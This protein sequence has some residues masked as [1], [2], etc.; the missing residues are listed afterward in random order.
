M[1]DEFRAHLWSA[2][3]QLRTDALQKFVDEQLLESLP[4]LQEAI[5]SSEF[6]EQPRYKIAEAVGQLTESSEAQQF[7][8]ELSGQEDPFV[9]CCAAVGMK[10][11]SQAK[12]IIRLL[13]MLEDPTNKVRN[14]AERSLLNQTEAL[15]EHGQQKLLS[16][17]DHPT[18]LIRSPAARLAG[19]AKMKA[20]L[21]KLLELAQQNP[22]WLTRIWATKALGDMGEKS[23][24]ETL[25]LIL[26]QDEKNRVRAAAVESIGVLK[27]HN[28]EALLKEALNDDDAGVQ[29]RASEMLAE[30]GFEGLGADEYEFD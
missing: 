6:G 9:R 29:K 2:D 10:S 20:A 19:S 12:A 15:C 17:L 27:P 14:E 28:A 23:A 22:E 7:L 4:L 8:I 26:R 3:E 21:P 18:P 30:L 25:E 1:S 5:V 13:E 16:L 11:F 24:C